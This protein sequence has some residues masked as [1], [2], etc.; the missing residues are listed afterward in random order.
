VDRTLAPARFVVG[1]AK[2]LLIAFQTFGSAEM[3]LCPAVGTVDQAG[4]QALSACGRGSA[5]VLS[6]FLDSQPSILVNDRLLHIGDDLLLLHRVV[7]GLVDLVADGGA[8]EVYGATGVLPV[9]KNVDDCLAT[10][11]TWIFGDFIGVFSS[12]GF[13]VSAGDKDLL[14]F[15]LPCDLGRPSSRKAEVVDVPYHLCRRLVN[16]PLLL[17]V[18]ISYIAVRNG[19]GNAFAVFSLAFPY[20]P[21]LLRGLSGVP[22]VR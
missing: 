4:K 8:F 17:I 19:G 5:L 2:K 6:Q 20:L 16:E 11:S 9:F 12:Y 13:V 3:E 14:R 18:C 7:N 10:P 22:L 1:A 21:D 15:K